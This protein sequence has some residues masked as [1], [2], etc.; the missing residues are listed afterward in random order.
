MGNPTAAS[1]LVKYGQWAARD[2]DRT[3]PASCTAQRQRH[4]RKLKFD[5]MLFPGRLLVYAQG[6]RLADDLAEY[7]GAAQ[8]SFGR[9]MDRILYGF[10]HGAVCIFGVRMG[11]C[12]AELQMVRR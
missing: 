7:Y 11:H 5:D 4:T 8:C 2:P 1:S 3:P 12:V 6:E 9:V 10:A